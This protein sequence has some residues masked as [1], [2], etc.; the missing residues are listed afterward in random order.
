[1]N[2]IRKRP[3]PQLMVA[4]ASGPNVITVPAPEGFPAGVE[5]ANEVEPAVQSGERPVPHSFGGPLLGLGGAELGTQL[6]GFLQDIACAARALLESGPSAEQRRVLSFI[7]SDGEGAL[8]LMDAV[9]DFQRLRMGRGLELEHAEFDLRKRVEDVVDV[10]ARRLAPK[11]VD[12]RLFADPKLPALAC[13][14]A[15]RVRRALWLLVGFSSAFDDAPTPL[16]IHV[17]HYRGAF[18]VEVAGGAPM[19][20]TATIDWLLRA[21]LHELNEDAPGIGLAIARQL[22][23]AMEGDLSFSYDAERGPVF[24]M[25]LPLPAQVAKVDGRGRV[26]L[27]C[28]SGL[29]V[30]SDAAL[31]VHLAALAEYWGVRTDIV[32]TPEEACSRLRAARVSRAPYDW[33]LAGRPAREA[34]LGDSVAAISAAMDRPTKLLVMR[35]SHQGMTQSLQSVATAVIDKPVRFSQLVAALEACAPPL[36][37]ESAFDKVD[38]SV[39]P[40]PLSSMDWS[41]LYELERQDRG[42]A[43]E[44]AELFVRTAP[45]GLEELRRALL[46][47]EVE[48]AQRACHSLRGAA[49]QL[50]ISNIARDLAEV[51]GTLRQRRSSSDFSG[52]EPLR[53][54]AL[55]VEDVGLDLDD[56]CQLIRE[57]FDLD[58]DDG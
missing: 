31:R 58:E 4:V 25:T 49:A 52:E 36:L 16:T 33:V 20:D 3:R 40:P 32:A 55:F 11:G 12:V 9:M 38:T 42:V 44:V 41:V 37:V 1:M 54:L 46:S 17:C 18:E 35:Y 22:A 6:R 56:A 23:L 8:D 30:E 57:R 5:T 26:E 7:R 43:K 47:A 45:A 15:R 28:Q 2:P 19:L 50:G 53:A 34:E 14:D 10:A 24:T 13:G 29:I 27:S 39:P 51:E 48:R 21:E